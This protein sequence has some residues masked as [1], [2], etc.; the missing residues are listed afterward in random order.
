MEKKIRTVLGITIILCLLAPLNDEWQV[1]IWFYLKAGTLM[2]VF[3]ILPGLVNIPAALVKS[4]FTLRL[5]AIVF[6]FF[7]LPSLLIWNFYQIKPRA[8]KVKKV[9]RIWLSISLASSLYISFSNNLNLGDGLS[10]SYWPNPI[11]LLI[12]TVIEIWLWYR[13]RREKNS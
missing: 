9:Y 8:T 12:A 2:T 6:W 7:A 1:G 4:G 10:V 13:E 5:L 11:L 3:T